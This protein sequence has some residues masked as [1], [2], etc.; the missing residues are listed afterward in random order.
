MGREGVQAAPHCSMGSPLRTVQLGLRGAYKADSRTGMAVSAKLPR[1]TER[2]HAGSPWRWRADTG[3]HRPSGH[4][5]GTP[6]GPA[7]AGVLRSIS[8]GNRGPPL[9]AQREGH[10]PTARTGPLSVG[11]KGRLSQHPQRAGSGPPGTR[12]ATRDRGAGPAPG[13]PR[14]GTGGRVSCLQAAGFRPRRL[15][16]L[17]ARLCADTGRNQAS[18][19]GVRTSRRQKTELNP[20]NQVP[21]NTGRPLKPPSADGLSALF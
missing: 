12:D 13:H 16:R 9:C 4:A 7:P 5:D 19:R 8:L 20:R 2:P 3:A 14:Q 11:L 17:P 18:V 15:L 10:C 6:A 21:P 1:R